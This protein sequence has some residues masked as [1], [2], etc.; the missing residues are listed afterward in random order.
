MASY[1]SNDWVIE[2]VIWEDLGRPLLSKWLLA[3][4]RLQHWSA[5]NWIWL[6]CC[7]ALHHQGLCSNGQVAKFVLPVRYVA[8]LKWLLFLD[9]KGQSKIFP[10]LLERVWSNSTTYERTSYFLIRD[11]PYGWHLCRVGIAYAC[12]P[13]FIMCPKSKIITQL[14]T[15]V[16]SGNGGCLE[17]EK[18]SASTFRVSDYMQYE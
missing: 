17:R 18:K 11:Q 16:W 5:S 3:S 8:R 2:N 1:W 15:L 13:S 9:S 10:N 6:F 12:F 14:C 4:F 7:F